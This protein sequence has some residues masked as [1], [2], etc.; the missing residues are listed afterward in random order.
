MAFRLF[1]RRDEQ[2]KSQELAPRPAT[3]SN[4]VVATSDFDM[5]GPILWQDIRF[6]MSLSEVRAIRPEVVR[7]TDDTRLG[8]G[9]MAELEIPRL[10]LADHDYRVLIYARAERVVQV[11]I[12]TLGG[13]TQYDFQQLTGALRLRY[14]QEVE[15]NEDPDGLSSA[16]WLSPEGINVSLVCFP[17]AGILN[18]VFQNRYSEAARQL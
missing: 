11:T 8:D 15:M 3:I 12:S 16:E 7:P 9:T 17:G 14:G 1:G 5:L 13:P 18:V 10:R 2:A 4:P 6:G